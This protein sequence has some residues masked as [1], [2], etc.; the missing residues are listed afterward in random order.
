MSTHITEDC[1][2]C[3]ACIPECPNEAIAEG[4]GLHVIDPKLCTECVGFN[5]SEACQKVC[6]TECCV[7]DPTHGESESALIEKAIRLHSSDEMK[8]KFAAGKFPSRFRT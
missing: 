7:P 4:D 5:E 6:P 2:N 1:I 8:A 3:G